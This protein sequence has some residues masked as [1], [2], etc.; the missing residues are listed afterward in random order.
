M[1]DP[2]DVAD[3]IV[4]LIA[5]AQAIEP[6]PDLPATFTAERVWF[7]DPSAA[8]LSST[9]VFIVPATVED[10]MATHGGYASSEIG[11]T[12]CLL[13]KVANKTNAVCDP[14]HALLMEIKEYLYTQKTVAN[15]ALLSTSHLPIFIENLKTSS[16]FSAKFTA[17]YKGM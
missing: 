15:T 12:V 10:V 14:L 4:A 8:S 17:I 2:I 11:I 9:K 7:A 13:R 5:A 3:G 1:I 16:V 6:T